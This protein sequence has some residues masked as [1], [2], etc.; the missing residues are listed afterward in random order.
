MYPKIVKVETKDEYIIVVKFDNN[1]VVEYDLKPKLE[2][3]TFEPL[4]DKIFFSTIKIDNGGY[5]ISWDDEIDLSEYEVWT[6]G[7]KIS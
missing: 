3:K 5:G 2:E 6:K 1:D 7:K 4:K